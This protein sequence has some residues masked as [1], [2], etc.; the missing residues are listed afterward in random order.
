MEG[1]LGADFLEVAF[2]FFVEVF[3]LILLLS[4]LLSFSLD[5][6]FSSAASCKVDGSIVLYSFLRSI[7]S[8]S[9][10]AVRPI[11]ETD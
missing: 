11:A 3:G 6:M 4:F 9:L 5:S 8:V 10:A 1:G 7:L 2:D